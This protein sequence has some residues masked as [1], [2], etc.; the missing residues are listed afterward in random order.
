MKNGCYYLSP[1]T[2]QF[3][4]CKGLDCNNSDIA[5]IFR[6]HTFDKKKISILK[7]K[8]TEKSRECQS[9]EEAKPKFD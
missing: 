3:G 2:R 4:K 8:I 5:R 7:S 9:Q 6:N 1:G